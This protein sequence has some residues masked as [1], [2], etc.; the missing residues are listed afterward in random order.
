MAHWSL[1][2]HAVAAW[3]VFQQ[4]LELRQADAG[5]DGERGGTTSWIAPPA[6]TV[7]TDHY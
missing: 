2:V 4:A 7:Q 5:V 1:Y 6:P 3:L